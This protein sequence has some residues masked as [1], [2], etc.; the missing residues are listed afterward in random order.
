M[1]NA[2]AEVYNNNKWY[3]LKKKKKK[4]NSKPQLDFM[5]PIKLTTTTEGIEKK[6]KRRKTEKKY[7]KE[8]TEQVKT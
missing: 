4:H 7:P 1:P 8:C 3:D 6:K 5:V 2:E